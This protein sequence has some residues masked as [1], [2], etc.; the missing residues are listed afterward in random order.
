MGTS[1]VTEPKG[2]GSLANCA[3]GGNNNCMRCYNTTKV[4]WPIGRKQYQFATMGDQR[5]GTPIQSAHA[6]GA[7]CLMADGSVQF[8]NESLDLTVFKNMVDRD[9]GKV[10]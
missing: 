8:L 10:P 2:P 1:Y 4:V 5:C 3:G 7:N 9:D 6:G